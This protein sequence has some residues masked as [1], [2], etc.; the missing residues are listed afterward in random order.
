MLR[1]WALM[2]PSL[3]LS[4]LVDIGLNALSTLST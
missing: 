1:F 2:L 4:R 3:W